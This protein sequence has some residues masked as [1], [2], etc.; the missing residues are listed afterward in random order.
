MC[1]RNVGQSINRCQ[2]IYQMFKYSLLFRCSFNSYKTISRPDFCLVKTKTYS[3][4]CE[5]PSNQV[6]NETPTTGS[7][8][9]TRLSSKAPLSSTPRPPRPVRRTTE[10]T[11]RCMI[12]LRQLSAAVHLPLRSLGILPRPADTYHNS[13]PTPTA[14]TTK[15]SAT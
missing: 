7:Q 5:D 1:I 9:P 2:K 15:L 4:D 10:T 8:T 3:T 13:R 11:Q 14:Y 6:G 12:S